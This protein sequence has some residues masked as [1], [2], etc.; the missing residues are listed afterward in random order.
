MKHIRVISLAV[1]AVIGAVAIG[2]VAAQDGNTANVEVRV[3]QSTQDSEQLY[4]SARPEGGSWRTLG[5]IPLDMSGLNSRE[6]FRYGDITV[7]V[8]VADPALTYDET[9][10]PLLAFTDEGK[11]IP[12]SDEALACYEALEWFA[13]EIWADDWDAEQ[14]TCSGYGAWSHTYRAGFIATGVARLSQGIYSLYIPF[15]ISSVNGQVL[16]RL[17]RSDN[18]RSLAPGN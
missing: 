16:Y 12:E 9:G 17:W 6:T 18:L 1:I 3:W 11:V 5:T 14:V 8:P 10:R 2:V 4:I 15:H 13:D 7:G